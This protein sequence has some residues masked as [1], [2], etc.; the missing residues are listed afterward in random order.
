MKKQIAKGS[1]GRLALATIASLALG[2]GVTPAPD[3]AAGTASVESAFSVD[4]FVRNAAWVTRAPMPTRRNAFGIA[5]L[6]GK[7]YVVGGWAQTDSG[8]GPTATLEV[9]DPATNTWAVKAPMP[10]PRNVLAAAAL[11]GKLYA[12]GGW[13]GS[14]VTN[15]VEVYDPRSDSWSVGT[16]MNNPSSALSAAVLNGKIYAMGGSDVEVYDPQKQAWTTTV[17]TGW[18]PRWFLAAAVAKGK[19]YAM[20]G[21]DSPDVFGVTTFYDVVQSYDPVADAWTDEAPLLFPRSEGYAAAVDDT[22]YFTGGASWY[23]FWWGAWP[24]STVEA[25]DACSGRWVTRAPMSSGRNLGGAASVNG[26]LY[27]VG[28]WD[29]QGATGSMEEYVYPHAA[30]SVK[31]DTCLVWGNDFVTPDYQFTTNTEVLVTQDARG[32]VIVTCRAS[33][34]V[35]GTGGGVFLRSTDHPGFGCYVFN[36]WLPAIDDWFEYIAPNGDATLVCHE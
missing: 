18:A 16:P 3:P 1:A 27:A 24:Q 35:N 7:I 6:K 36:A 5:T 8:E 2:C 14:E 31:G 23:V 21:S 12:M 15:R 20:G 30:V 28:G 26:R 11:G 32:H 4:G 22:I 34:L 25:F 17:S 10:T 13:T 29:S 9:Y 33:G 19:L